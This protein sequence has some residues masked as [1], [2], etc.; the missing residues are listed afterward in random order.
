MIRIDDTLL[1]EI[2]LISLPKAER[3]QMLR[4]IYETLEM[5]VGM[6]L[7][8]RMT[9]QQLDE[10]ERFIDT[11]DEAGAL[12]WL[13]T[14]FPDYKQVVA[15]ELDKL[16]A[17]IKKDSATILQTMQ[18]QPPQTGVVSQPQPQQQPYAPQ[19]MPQPVQSYPA[20]TQPYANPAPHV[21]QAGAP[22]MDQAQQQPATQAFGQPVTPPQTPPQSDFTQQSLPPAPGVQPYDD[23][24]ADTTGSTSTGSIPPPPSF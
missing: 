19:Q 18:V 9:D 4:Q 11:N 5:R 8:E 16:K 12:K 21:S 7:A 15:D 17:E 6:K 1:E 24:S 2:G 22:S 10:F 23:Q 20:P 3:D 13:E 14:N